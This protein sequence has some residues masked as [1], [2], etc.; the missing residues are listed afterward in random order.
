MV[1]NGDQRQS[2]VADGDQR[3]WM[4]PSQP[5]PP[6]VS[7]KDQSGASTLAKVNSQQGEGYFCLLRNI[8]LQINTE[9]FSYRI[10]SKARIESFPRTAL[11]TP[12]CWRCIQMTRLPI[13]RRTK[14]HQITKSEPPQT[15]VHFISHKICKLNRQSYII[16]PSHNFLDKVSDLIDNPYVCVGKILTLHRMH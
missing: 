5:I 3:K 16:F 1:L 10:S 14:H 7:D 2:M 9:S 12:A 13:T 6:A 11:D 4:E 15:C 8:A